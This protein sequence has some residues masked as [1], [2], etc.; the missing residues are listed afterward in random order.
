[1][2]KN[3]KKGTMPKK[4]QITKEQ[5]EKKKASF[6]PYLLP[7]MFVLGV[8]PLIV[9]LKIYDTHLE[10]FDFFETIQY[11]D[12]FLYYKQL[13]FITACSIM[14]LLIIAQAGLHHRKIKGLK[15]FIPLGGYALLAL[16]SAIFS[17]YSQFSFSGIFEHFESVW[18]LLGYALVAYYGF[19]FVSTAKD[20]DWLLSALTVGT[21]IMLLI[22]LSQAFSHDIFRSDFGRGLI[23]PYK[24]LHDENLQLNFG[25]PEDS[26]YLT[27]FNPNYVG[28]YVCLLAPVFL[29]FAFAKK[30]IWLV[31]LNIV[32]FVGLL[33]CILG[34]GSRAGFIGIAFSLLLLVIIFNKKLI[35]FLP[36][37]IIVIVLLIGVVYTYNNLSNGQL[38]AR[39]KLALDIELKN[40][41]LKSIETNDNDITI[42]YNDRKISIGHTVN[43]STGSYIIFTVDE[44]GT[45]IPYTA[46]KIESADGYH[47]TTE[48]ERFKNI[49]FDF[50][51]LKNIATFS[52]KIDDKVWHFL[53][54]EDMNHKYSYFYYNNK[55]KAVKIRNAEYVESLDK[56]GR[57]LSNRL[58]IWS[59]TI[60]LLKDNIILGTGPDTFILNFP[61][62]DYVAM[63][64]GGYERELLTKPHNMYLQI[65]V[66]TGVLSLICF[67]AFYFWYFI[68]S[69]KLYMKADKAHY[70][71]SMIGIG[72][73]CGTFGYMI[74]G[75]INDS[76]IVVAPL[77][78]TLIGIGIAIN[79]MIKRDSA[80]AVIETLEPDNSDK[81]AEAPV[82]TPVTKEVQ[83]V[84]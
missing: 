66:Q 44:Y 17:E 24:Y 5:A 12:V 23:L 75:M 61:N 26:V 13:F 72:I 29:M 48:D 70:Y 47:F 73:L 52:I 30:K 53:Y 37:A 31:I 34:S 15:L 49:S 82:E 60:P 74:V 33:L 63:Y 42:N 51:I 6:N 4:E 67:L 41:T 19:L 77:F 84:K 28:S 3:I 64:N 71:P 40:P 39:A 25:F 9:H 18:A 20:L 78:W 59:Y 7:L 65:G 68:S 45:T 2:G 36:E 11:A 38:V 57:A 21:V 35:K 32:I 79:S 76:M 16:L 1:M 14:L 8:L 43:G 27:L 69:I 58:F 46:V 56:Y 22:G 10:D 81:E 50:E 55:K 62:D 54:L 83:A 80:F